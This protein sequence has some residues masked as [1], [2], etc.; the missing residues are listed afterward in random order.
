MSIEGRRSASAESCT[1]AAAARQ[2]S[3][4]SSRPSELTLSNIVIPNRSESEGRN[5]LSI[6]DQIKADFSLRFEIRGDGRAL[7]V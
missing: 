6:W 4:R 3:P 5:L 2:N 7:V 1:F